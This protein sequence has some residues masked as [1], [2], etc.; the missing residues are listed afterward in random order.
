MEEADG[1]A[2]EFL[3]RLFV[4]LKARQTGDAVALEAAMKG[5]TRQMGIVAFKV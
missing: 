1:V 4:T 5:R 3:F 2:F